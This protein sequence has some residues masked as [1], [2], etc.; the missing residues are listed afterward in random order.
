MF[1]LRDSIRAR[2][3][4]VVTVALIV[5]NVVGFVLE[6]QGGMERIVGT[7]G[8]VPATLVHGL[9]DGHPTA[10]LPVATSMFLHGDLLHLLGNLWFL[11]IFGDNVEDR[12]GRLGYVGFYL[13]CGVVAAVSQVVADPTSSIPMVGASGAIAGVLGAYMW[14]FPGARVLTAVPLFIFIQLIEI[15]ALVFLGIWFVIQLVS[16]FLGYGGVAWWAHIAGFVAGLLLSFLVGASAPRSPRP[17][18]RRRVSAW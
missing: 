7:W 9:G 5:L 14:L 6:V 1:P 4:P 16:S 2:R 18:V 15:R 12:F 8:L 13:T 3:F 17:R 11:W 10:I